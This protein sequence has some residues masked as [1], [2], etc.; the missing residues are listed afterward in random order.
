MYNICFLDEYNENVKDLFGERYDLSDDLSQSNVLVTC[1]AS[2]SEDMLSSKLVFAVL[3]CSIGGADIPEAFCSEHGIVIFRASDDLS[4]PVLH[5]R[6]YIENGN[7]TDSVNFPDVSLGA[8][9]DDVSR[10]SIVMTGIDD[11]ILLG[12]MMFSGMDLKAVAG[13]TKKEY[14]YALVLSREPVISVPHVDGVIKVRVLQD[15]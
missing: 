14:G 15:I 10:I 2:L 11:P 7:I 8:F 13:G 4:D 3:D 1:G 12:A 6:D 9:S 5:V